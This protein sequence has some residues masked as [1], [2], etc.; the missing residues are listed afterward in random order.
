MR[1]IQLTQGLFSLV[2]DDDYQKLSSYNWSANCL[3]GRYYAVARLPGKKGVTVLLHRFL[4]SADS[5]AYIDHI[6]GD[7]LD[8]R[9]S[10]LRACTNSQNSRNSRKL[11]TKKTSSKYK[12]VCLPKRSKKWLAYITVDRRRINLGS[13]TT[14][15][16][17]A[18]AY[19][20]AAVK[21]FGEFARLND[22]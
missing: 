1:E 13:F 17:A 10:N 9:R 15:V 3:G 4:L 12:G 8:N 21:L 16:E 18:K 22:V 7:T 5:G 19:N 11:A 14:E 2:D 6:N 20:E